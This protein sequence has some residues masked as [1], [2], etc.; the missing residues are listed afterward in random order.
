[1][2]QLHNVQ[3]QPSSEIIQTGLPQ[4]STF[5]LTTSTKPTYGNVLAYSQSGNGNVFLYD[6]AELTILLVLPPGLNAKFEP[7]DNIKHSGEK[8]F[9]TIH[10][11][12]NGYPFYKNNQVHLDKIDIMFPGSEWR[13]N[14]IDP[15]PPIKAPSEPLL[16]KKI[17]IIHNGENVPVSL[18][19]YNDKQLVVFCARDLAGD[20]N[21]LSYWKRY[22]CP[23][24]P[25]GYSDGYGAWKN[26]QRAINF[27]KHTFK[28]PDLESKY[29]K[30]VAIKS[31][32]TQIQHNHFIIN[33][34]IMY[35]SISAIMDVVEISAL[36]LNIFF[37]PPFGINGFENNW[38]NDLNHPTK[39]KMGGFMF[40]KG[41]TDIISWLEQTF[42]LDKFEDRY[43]LTEEASARA[44]GTNVSSTISDTISNMSLTSMA[45]LPVN[46][47]LRLLID[48]INN[49]EYYNRPDLGG[50]ILIIGPSEQAIADAANLDDMETEIEVIYGAKRAIM[51]K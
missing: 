6:V 43:E 20:S 24:A 4:V 14:L 18:Y 7:K 10:G 12:K 25:S 9:S 11:Q 36:A 2:D 5:N 26:N 34:P 23:E 44:T 32:P 1:M 19:E 33:K 45:D 3:I 48:K 29:V 28:F 13:K 31:A 39:G 35:G 42:L 49:T 38:K 8:M 41:R 50:K 16:M 17:N 37:D 30:S 22:V 47:L 21:I 27:L 51:L 15:L 40:P 46:T